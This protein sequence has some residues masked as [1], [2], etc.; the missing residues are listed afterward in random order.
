M[1]RLEYTFGGIYQDTHGVS[2]IVKV[3]DSSGKRLDFS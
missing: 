1:F 3:N 2:K